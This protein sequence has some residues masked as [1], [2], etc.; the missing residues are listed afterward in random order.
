MDEDAHNLI[1]QG[2]AMSNL[3]MMFRM[4]RTTVKERLAKGGVKPIGL[5]GRVPVYDIAEAAGYLVK[6]SYDIETYVRRMSHKDL[7]KELTKEFWAGQRSRQE[8]ELKAG[9][10]WPTDRV[11]AEVGELFKLVKMSALLMMDAVE[12]QSELSDVQREVIKNLTHGML[13]DLHQRIDKNFTA[14]EARPQDIPEPD[15][16]QP[17]EDDDDRL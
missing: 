15:H 2:A 8:Y 10:L 5:R 4:D 17:Q 3:A 9:N 7:P 13:D 11:I 1:Y 12:R 14:P 6:P 16:V